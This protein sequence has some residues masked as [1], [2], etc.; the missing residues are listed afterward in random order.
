MT[1]RALARLCRSTP[2]TGLIPANRAIN[3]RVMEELLRTERTIVTQIFHDEEAAITYLR[4][5]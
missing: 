1:L 5:K 2:P 3:M 4:G